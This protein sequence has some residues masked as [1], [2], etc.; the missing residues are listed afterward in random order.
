[1]SD[2]YGQ[3]PSWGQPE[4]QGDRGYQ[5]PGPPAPT[6]GYPGSSYPTSGYPAPDPW[7]PPQSPG[8]PPQS[9]PPQSRS[10]EHI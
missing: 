6:S 1:M 8:Y 3:P 5:Q 10:E 4:Q 2:P 9:Y 7:G